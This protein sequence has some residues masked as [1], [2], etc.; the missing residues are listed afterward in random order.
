MMFIERCVVALQL[1][2]QGTCFARKPLQQALQGSQVLSV[3]Q[4]APENWHCPLS[5]CQLGAALAAKPQPL[6]SAFAL[7]PQDPYLP[8]LS[9]VSPVQ[10]T[11]QLCA[12]AFSPQP[13][14]L[15]GHLNFE[16]LK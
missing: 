15:A 16:M 13:C 11:K 4:G 6:A 5:L 2:S 9:L 1:K 12:L 7:R 10:N 3:F 14:L 8:P